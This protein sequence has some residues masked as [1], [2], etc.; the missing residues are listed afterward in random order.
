[1]FNNCASLF[2]IHF[3][4]SVDTDNTNLQLNRTFAF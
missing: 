1:M 4:Y 2:K 3:K